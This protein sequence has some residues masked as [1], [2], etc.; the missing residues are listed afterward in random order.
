MRGLRQQDNNELN[1]KII[2][3]FCNYQLQKSQKKQRKQKQERGKASSL[4]GTNE[5]IDSLEIV[6]CVIVPQSTQIF[7]VIMTVIKLYKD[8]KQ[9]KTKSQAF[10]SGRICTPCGACSVTEGWDYITPTSA[11]LCPGSA[12][13]ASFLTAIRPGF[14]TPRQ[15]HIVGTRLPALDTTAYPQGGQRQIHRDKDKYKNTKTNTQHKRQSS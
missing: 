4:I 12:F 11:F 10:R 7:I 1:I 14:T 15:R 6:P 13:M 8:M 3:C 2:F 5:D 9:K